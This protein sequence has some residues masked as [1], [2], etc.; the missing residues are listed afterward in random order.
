MYNNVQCVCACMCVCV[1]AFPQYLSARLAAFSSSL[2]PN[3]RNIVPRFV[4]FTFNNLPY[5]FRIVSSESVTNHKHAHIVN[6]IH[7]LFL[8]SQSCI[9][10]K[11]GISDCVKWDC[12]NLFRNVLNVLNVPSSLCEV[13]YRSS[14]SL[15]GNVMVCLFTN[16]TLYLMCLPC[17]PET[18][19]TE[20]ASAPISHTLVFQSHRCVFAVTGFTP[21][22]VLILC[23]NGD[24]ALLIA[25]GMFVNFVEMISR[26]FLKDASPTA[27]NC[28]NT[29]NTE[30]RQNV[31]STDS[32]PFKTFSNMPSKTS[33]HHLH[34][35]SFFF[36]YPT[37]T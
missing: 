24:S 16:S 26:H 27:A 8:F 31:S 32:T 29:N 11:L 33:Q 34:C 22:N 18:L 23:P 15:K 19:P 21:Y 28:K 4:F 5:I 6:K 9:F 13:E 1:C 10:L 2:F 20:S 17:M 7:F 14:S 37:E 30:S 35:V 12:F 25:D 36:F 3:L